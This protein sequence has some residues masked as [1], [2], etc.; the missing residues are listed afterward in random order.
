MTPMK[1]VIV[2]AGPTAVGKTALTLQLAQSLNGEIVSA[3]SM[4]IYRRLNIGSAKPSTEEMTLVPHHM[5][6]IADPAEPYS[7]S[8]YRGAAI[9]A[10]RGILSRGKLPIVSGGTGLYINALLYEMDFSGTTHDETFRLTMEQL[11]E[12]DGPEAL[13]QRL[14]NIDPEAA[15]NIH[16]NNTKRVIRALEINEVGGTKKSD[17][18]KQTKF[19]HEFSFIFVCLTRPRAELYDRINKRVDM[20]MDAGLL[21]EVNAL[22]QSGI[23]PNCQSM[24]GIGYK[25]L[26]PVVCGE[27]RLDEA[28]E[29]I[30][31]SSRNYA[32]RQMTWFKRYSEATWIDVSQYDDRQTLEIVKSMLY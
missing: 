16:P 27:S 11:L 14:K 9:E 3:D 1:P 13:Y 32:K 25:E 5:I 20:M 7:V 19:N 22:Y 28:V 23:G 2:I 12:K 29:K 15:E 10:M 26:L 18:S 30:K 6:D 8:D 21:E 31:Q 17:F 4:Q 24:Q